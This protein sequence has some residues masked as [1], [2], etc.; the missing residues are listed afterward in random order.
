MADL[1][2]LEP[3]K[4][5]LST[6]KKILILM[7]PAPNT[8]V[9]ATAL[10][11]G[12]AL[13][14]AGHDVQVASPADM[15]VEF[16]RLV[17]VDKVKKKIANRNL[18]VSFPYSEDRV[19]KVSYNISEDGNRF[20]L[21]IAPK[22][23]APPLDPAQVQY[24]YAGAEAEVVITVGVSQFNELGNMYEQDRNVMEGAQSLALTL[25]PV[26]TFANY[27]ADAQGLSCMSELGVKL[28]EYFNLP[29]LQDEAN[30]F[31][32]GL[33]AA[34]NGLSSPTMTA[35]T[36]ELVAKLLRAGAKRQP[37]GQH[38]TIQPN[39]LPFTQNSVPQPKAGPPGADT[40][41]FAA[42]M[43][44]IPPANPTGPTQYSATN[45]FKG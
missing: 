10:G 9:A 14:A 28:C 38:N 42:A 16:S 32:F 44:G 6:P 33:E 24:D 41:Q 34:T 15:R 26:G 13:Q 39:Q 45:E 30:N 21:I 1:S 31:L 22:T 2:S 8:D 12:V 27:Q 18:V 4:N 36:F 40:S 3:L 5:V 25:F 43:S 23:N 20:N 7:S 17:G 11:L 19:E 35:D 29:L 37:M